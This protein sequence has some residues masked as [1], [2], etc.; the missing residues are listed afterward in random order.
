MYS[1]QALRVAREHFSCPTLEG[2]PLENEGG[3]SSASSHWE[4]RALYLEIMT[5][6]FIP[7][8]GRLGCELEAVWVTV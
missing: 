2:I 7:G 5:S 4:A 1:P 3:A 6:S 8:L